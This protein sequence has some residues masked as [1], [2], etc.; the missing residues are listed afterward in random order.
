MMYERGAMQKTFYRAGVVALLCSLATAVAAPIVI[1]VGEDDVPAGFGFGWG[2][3]ERNDERSF[4]WIR[5]MEA[6]LWVHVDAPSAAEIELLAAAYYV[7]NKQQKFGLYVND[8]FVA[9]WAFAHK[10]GWQFETFK[11]DLP[12]GCLKAGRNRITLRVGYTAWRGYAIAV[13]RVVINFR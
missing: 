8:Q 7:P 6:D 12:Q 3:F 10:E 2:R 4:A 13:D 1:D 5:H 11:A 9:E